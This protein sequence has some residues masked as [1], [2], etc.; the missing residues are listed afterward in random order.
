MPH[1][2]A[3]LN[4]KASMMYAGEAPWHC[5]G[6]RL[7]DPATAAEAIT[8]AGLNHGVTLTSLSTAA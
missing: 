7:D 5:P 1:E 2:L 4:G 3:T 8:A 6:T